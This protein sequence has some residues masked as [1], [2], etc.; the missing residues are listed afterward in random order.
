[1]KFVRLAVF[2]SCREAWYLLCEACQT[3]SF[4]LTEHHSRQAADSVSEMRPQTSEG[5]ITN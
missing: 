5:D 4:L 2:L 3:K 1:M